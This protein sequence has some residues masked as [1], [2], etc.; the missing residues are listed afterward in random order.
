MQIAGGEREVNTDHEQE[1]VGSSPHGFRGTRNM[2]S[3]KEVG[4]KGGR[5]KRVEES[6][7]QKETRWDYLR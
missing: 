3:E 6:A 7:R 2:L 4:E 5:Y 1:Q